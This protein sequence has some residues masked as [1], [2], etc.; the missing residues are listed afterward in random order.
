MFNAACQSHR[1]KD[2]FKVNTK[3]RS[4]ISIKQVLA[5]FKLSDGLPILS[6]AYVNRTEKFLGSSLDPYSLPNQLKWIQINNEGKKK[7][8]FPNC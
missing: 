5:V 4:K 1:F 3:N 2:S 8:I 6:D 7:I